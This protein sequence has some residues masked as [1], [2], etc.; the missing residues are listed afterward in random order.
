VGAGVGDGGGD[1]VGVCVVFVVVL[2]TTFGFASLLHPTIAVAAKAP[3]ARVA[4]TRT[5]NVG[6]VFDPAVLTSL[7]GSWAIDPMAP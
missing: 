2:G 6:T 3:T 1:G 7:L 4:L 5:T